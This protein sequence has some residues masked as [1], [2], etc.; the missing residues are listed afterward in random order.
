M[1]FWRFT[2]FPIRTVMSD[3]SRDYDHFVRRDIVFYNPGND[4]LWKERYNQIPAGN[5][6]I[7]GKVFIDDEPAKNLEFSLL[8]ANGRKTLKTKVGPDGKYKISLPAGKYFFNG[9]LIFNKSSVINDKF[10]INAISKEEGL[11]ILMD[12]ANNKSIQ[13]EYLKLEKQLGP[14]GA[15]KK[16]LKNFAV[17]TPFNDKFPF[18]IGDKPFAFPDLYYRSP[19]IVLLPANNAKVALKN[20]MFIWQPVPKASYY[21]ATITQI[22]RKGTT[23][24]YRNA[25]TL[26]HI[27][28]NQIKYGDLL[29]KAAKEN[30]GDECD[31]IED[32]KENELYGFRVVAYNVENQIVTA[33]SDEPNK[34]AV[35]S[36]EK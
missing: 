19:I 18:E 16:L 33:S 2:G 8:L 26:S 34:L 29:E 31:R 24:S 5:G 9:I 11:S 28:T 21:K 12:H 10:L 20:L 13:A 23:T 22:E 7:D 27:E 25:L 15:A 6:E 14:E 3:N 36:V 17:S 1:L 4:D 32:L 35:F 30:A